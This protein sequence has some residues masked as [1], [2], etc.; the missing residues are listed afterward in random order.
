[1]RLR[2]HLHYVIIWLGVAFL[3]AVV[4]SQTTIID[5]N[6]AGGSAKVIPGKEYIRS[7]Y[8]NFFWGRQYRREWNTAVRV[9]VLYL[10]SAFSGMEISPVTGRIQSK[11]LLITTSAGKQYLLRSVNRDFGRTMPET[12]GTFVSRIAK[13]QVSTLHPY[14]P[15]T[16]P[17]MAE[18][19]GIPHSNPRIVF[20]PKQPELGEYNSAYGDELYFLGD[21]GKPGSFDTLETDGI[22]SSYQLIERFYGENDYEVDQRAFVRARLFDMI[23]G[24]WN[25]DRDNWQWRL[26]DRGAMDVFHPVPRNRSQAYSKINGLYPGLAGKIP[27][28]KFLQGFDYKIKSIGGWNRQARPIDQKL[29]NELTLEEWLTEA[30][31]LQ[32]ALSDEV[33]RNSVQEMPAEVFHISGDEIISKLRTRRDDLQK[34]ARTYYRYLARTVSILGSEKTE[35]LEVSCLPGNDVKVEMYKINSQGNI[36]DTP[37]YSRTFHHGETRE[38]Y[39]YGLGGRDII[40]IKGDRR[41][42][43]RIRIIDPED[44]DSVYVLADTRSVRGIRFFKG[45]KFEYDTIRKDKIDFEFLPVFTP[46]Q[47]RAYDFDPLDLFGRTGVKVSAGVVYTPQPWRREPY[48]MTH[49]IH[50]LHG[51]LRKTLNVGYV[52]RFGRA[53][54]HWDLLLK[55]RMDDPAVEN[56]FGVGNNTE[57]VEKKDKNYYRTFSQRYYAGIGIERKIAKRHHAELT[58]IYQAV[59][60]RRKGGYYIANGGHD[61]SIFNRKHFAGIEAGYRFDQTNGS[62]CP[63]RG[64]AINFGG[65]VLQ[66][67]SDTG[68]AFVKLRSN[69]SFYLPLSREFTF[70]VRTG[71][72]ILIGD[73]DFYHLNRLGGNV[74]LR[75]YER[76]RFYGKHVFY[77]NT[78]LRWF[79][80]T[81]NYFYNG[82]IGLIGFYD[83]GRVWMPNEKSDKWHDGYGLGFAIVPYNKVTLIAMYG[84]SSEGDNFFLRAELFF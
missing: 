45:E 30:R 81:R 12:K 79:T 24:D 51:F 55:A 32:T 61:Q 67:L 7:G 57:F 50:V 70:A 27:G 39:L 82:R 25:R 56:F 66:N 37:Y 46:K 16:I 40:S 43:M 18:A 68:S 11:D 33:I 47:Y 6:Y 36:I 35:K 54:G 74:E 58:L 60:Y 34:Y 65:G 76:E 14:A 3:P 75:G 31:H 73:P 59:K 64:F 38:I 8:H 78:E 17:P 49:S 77:T 19:A 69:V 63:S 29:L 13:D 22:F 4:L 26:N 9:P 71:G 21:S 15:V 72:G 52:G 1:M 42:K 84:L 53:I 23:I 2:G 48:Q 62:V 44:K 20:V 28:R 5:S 10:D 41:N 83:I 80:D